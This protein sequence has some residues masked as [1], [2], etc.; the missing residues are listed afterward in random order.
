[1]MS[2]SG[3]EI[4]ADIYK[5]NPLRKYGCWL[6]YFCSIFLFSLLMCLYFYNYVEDNSLILAIWIMFL[7]IP[8]FGT[9]FVLLL[10]CLGDSLRYCRYGRNNENNDGVNLIVYK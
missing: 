3:D 2:E 7:I 5:E 1:M 4:Y 9:I 6:I 8:S 10:Y